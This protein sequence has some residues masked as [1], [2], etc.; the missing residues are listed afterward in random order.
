MIYNLMVII[1][2]LVYRKKFPDLER[3]YKVWGYPVTVIITILIFTALAVN[4]LIED[5]LTAIIGLVVPVAGVLLWWIFDHK[6]KRGT[7]DETSTN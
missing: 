3:P 5:P 1:A 4:T 7:P 6:L 2:V